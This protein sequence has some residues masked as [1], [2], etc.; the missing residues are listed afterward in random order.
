[1]NQ[2]HSSQNDTVAIYLALI[3]TVS[4]AEYMP[5]NLN[6]KIKFNLYLL[7]HLA[8]EIINQITF[9]KP[10]VFNAQHRMSVY[11]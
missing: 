11:V 1:M 10:Q 8:L 5:K 6:Q 2:D 3:R 7:G 9:C 4:I